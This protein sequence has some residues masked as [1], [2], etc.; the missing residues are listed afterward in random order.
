MPLD[1]VP[2]RCDHVAY[3][4]PSFR[5][6]EPGF[7]PARESRNP[8]IAAVCAFTPVVDGSPKNAQHFF[9]VPDYWIPARTSPLEVGL[10][11]PDDN[12]NAIALPPRGGSC[13][14]CM[15]DEAFVGRSMNPLTPHP[16]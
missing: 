5:P 14:E 1:R 13:G 16:S 8:V 10:A 3:P 15:D 11:W 9:G 7:G 4:S 2:V 12:P 6:S